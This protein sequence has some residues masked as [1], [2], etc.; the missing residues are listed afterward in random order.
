MEI[1]LFFIIGGLI[2]L[3]FPDLYKSIKDGKTIRY[4][5]DILLL[6]MLFGTIFF[7]PKKR[8]EEIEK[9]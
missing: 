1:L 8:K 9:K 3:V 7:I 5:I 6:I 4:I 2:G